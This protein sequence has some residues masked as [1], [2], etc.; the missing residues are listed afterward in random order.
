LIEI[1]GIDFNLPY[2]LKLNGEK[3]L[4]VGLTTANW[5]LID[6]AIYFN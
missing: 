5:G 1:R 4:T 3:E 6:F 2:L